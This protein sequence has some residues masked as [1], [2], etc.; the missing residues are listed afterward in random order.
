MK[1]LT[2]ITG[3]WGPESL[4]RKDG[5]NPIP[6][7]FEGFQK[8]KIPS[9]IP[10]VYF[11]EPEWQHLLSHREKEL[12]VS[13]PFNELS[14]VPSFDKCKNLKPFQNYGP[15]KDTL[16]FSIMSWSKPDLLA[17]VARSNPFNT[18]HFAWIDFGIAHVAD[19]VG[20]DWQEITQSISDKVR[21]CN[22]MAT[23]PHEILDLSQF[24]SFNRGRVASGFVT[25][26]AE[27]IDTYA[28][29]F[30]KE[31]ESM[32][33]SGWR[34]MDEMI[35]ATMLAR[36]P[37]N[38]ERYYANYNGILANY[39]KTRRDIENLMMNMNVCQSLGLSNEA[40]KIRHSLETF[41]H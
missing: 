40:I 12:V 34:V 3:F 7:Y 26:C 11:I 24:Y 35:M 37:A 16:E 31:H 14:Y 2:L 30:R 28:K 10:I 32:I 19:L 15:T 20:V 8:L 5:R 18:S 27:N 13:R 6:F 36:E 23:S 39:S 41:F 1:S 29:A 21:I 4:K 22:M 25:G 17:E 38:Y 33:E 9:D